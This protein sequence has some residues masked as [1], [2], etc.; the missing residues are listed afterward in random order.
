M[1]RSSA[2]ISTLFCLAQVEQ[3]NLPQDYFYTEFKTGIESIGSTVLVLLPW[4]DPI[5]LKRS[6]W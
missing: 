6:W 4:R 3:S 2:L 1:P 5:P